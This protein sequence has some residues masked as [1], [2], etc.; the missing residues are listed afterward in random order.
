MQMKVSI[1]TIKLSIVPKTLRHI[2]R[3]ICLKLK[4]HPNVSKKVT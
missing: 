1:Q 2:L 4:K 3:N